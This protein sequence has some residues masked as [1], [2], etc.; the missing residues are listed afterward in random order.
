MV[1]SIVIFLITFVSVW[2]YN[3]VYDVP[4]T[5]WVKFWHVYLYLM[6]FGGSA[7]LLWIIIGG[8]RDLIRLF[9][10]LRSQEENI[11]DDGSVIRDSYKEREST[12]V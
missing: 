4:V 11:L 7:F 1:I 10:N 3:L 9:K 2:I 8:I 5:S 12:V 6:F